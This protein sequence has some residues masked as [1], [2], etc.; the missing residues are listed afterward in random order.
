MFVAAGVELLIIAHIH[1]PEGGA[2][3]SKLDFD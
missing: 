2:C 3:S 1:D